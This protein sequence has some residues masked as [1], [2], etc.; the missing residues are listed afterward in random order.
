MP[1]NARRAERLPKIVGY[2]TAAAAP[3]GAAGG[4]VRLLVMCTRSGPRDIPERGGSSA[5]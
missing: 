3:P 5:G 1:M 2:A 4:V